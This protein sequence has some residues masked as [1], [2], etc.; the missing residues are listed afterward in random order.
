MERQRENSAG[1][2]EDVCAQTKAA[3][4]GKDRLVDRRH[5]GVFAYGED[6][7]AGGW[8]YGRCCQYSGGDG[9]AGK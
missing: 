8:E 1:E 4:D 9:C 2:S 7:V 6:S 5:V 3:M